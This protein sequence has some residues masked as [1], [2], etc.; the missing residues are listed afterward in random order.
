MVGA[1][2]TV[3]RCETS[4]HLG[5]D[6]A[7]PLKDQLA[8]GRA[9]RELRSRAGMTQEQLAALLVIDPTYVSQVERG[10]RGVRW[11]TVLRFLR[12]LEVTLGDLAAEI[13]KH[14]RSSRTRK[15]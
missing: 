9:L 13:E 4:P 15:D 8:L 14:D 1:Y 2:Y 3:R 12:A 6:G 7:D 10:R 5:A 11:Y